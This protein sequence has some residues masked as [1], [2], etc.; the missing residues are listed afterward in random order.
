M[1]ATTASR[2]MVVGV[3]LSSRLRGLASG[4]QG[5]HSSGG[6]GLLSR[7]DCRLLLIG[8][9]FIRF[10]RFDFSGQIF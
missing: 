2:S 4:Y 3:M 6:Y 7:I 8:E 9:S 5:S 1:R 10:D